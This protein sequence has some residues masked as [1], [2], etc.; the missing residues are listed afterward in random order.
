[1]PNAIPKPNL[2]KTEDDWLKIGRWEFSKVAIYKQTQGFPTDQQ[3]LV[4]LY[5]GN[6]TK[7]NTATGSISESKQEVHRT[8]S[9]DRKGVLTTFLKE[10]IRIIKV[11]FLSQ[12]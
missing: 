11:P 6:S 12:F 7:Y 9:E 1:M 2:M 3:H 5:S 4:I 10:I 8:T